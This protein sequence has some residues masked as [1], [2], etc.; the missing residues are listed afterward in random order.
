MESDEFEQQWRSMSEGDRESLLG[1]LLLRLNGK[2]LDVV[3][4]RALPLSKWKV[5][6]DRAIE[7]EGQTPFLL[8][9]ALMAASSVVALGLFWLNIPLWLRVILAAALVFVSFRYVRKQAMLSLRNVALLYPWVFDE[10]WDSGVIAVLSGGHTFSRLYGNRWQDVVL[11][12][13]G[14]PHLAN[15]APISHQEKLDEMLGPARV[16]K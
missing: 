10:Y 4:D 1:D 12:V 16:S 15:A 5:A 9:G 14:Y 11:R 7:I 13:I 2:E 3:V 8:Q 6:R